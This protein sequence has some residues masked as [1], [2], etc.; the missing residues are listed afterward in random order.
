MQNVFTINKSAKHDSERKLSLL[1]N[2]S[3]LLKTTLATICISD[4]RR[5]SEYLVMNMISA[6]LQEI[7]M[8]KDEGRLPHPPLTGCEL[9]KTE[10][11]TS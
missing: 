6:T 2:L 5:A 11:D 8:E 10:M 3:E 7:S 4:A 9:T 1:T